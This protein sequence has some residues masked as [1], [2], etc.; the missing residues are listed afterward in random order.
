MN[1]DPIV[2]EVRRLRQQ[3]AEGFDYDLRR[4]F[5]DLKRSEQAHERDQSPLLVVS[6]EGRKRSISSLWAARSARP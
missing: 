6:A 5:D 1:D 2:A 4:I 3:H